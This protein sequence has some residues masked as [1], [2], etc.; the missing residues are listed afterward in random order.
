MQV[1]VITAALALIGVLAVTA[2]LMNLREARSGVVAERVTVD[3][4]PAT[5]YRE[6]GTGRAPVVVIAH[7]F[8]GSE[9][10]MHSFAYTL[11]RNGLIAITFDFAGHG[12]NPQPLTGNIT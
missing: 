7:G 8:A 9:T 5:I 1:R 6:P 2:A 10:L 3:Q 4:I 12:R 11:A